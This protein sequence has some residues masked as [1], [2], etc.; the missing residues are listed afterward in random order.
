MSTTQDHDLVSTLVDVRE[1]AVGVP[2]P[3]L[4][5]VVAGGRRTVRRRRAGAAV[6]GGAAALAAVGI[7][8][9]GG[10]GSTPR[11]A[12]PAAPTPVTFGGCTLEPATCDSAPVEIG[13]LDEM[14]GVTYEPDAFERGREED[15]RGLADNARTLTYLLTPVGLP[16]DR[17]HQVATVSVDVATWLDEPAFIDAVRTHPAVARTDRRDVEIPGAGGVRANVLTGTDVDGGWFQFWVVPAGSGHGAVTISYE[18]DLPEGGS[19]TLGLHTTTDAAG[20]WTDE[21]VAGA[22]ADLLLG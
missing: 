3:D 2:G 9:A 21:R 10:L 18:G 7:A 1:D 16:A 14:T 11:A 4:D 17:G 6:A 22:I 12:D 20:G 13:M 8:V 15:L 5:A 19:P